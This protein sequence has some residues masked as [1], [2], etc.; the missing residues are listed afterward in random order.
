[1]H[2]RNFGCVRD[3]TVALTPLTVL[4]G[5]NDSGKSMLLR[6]VE[7]VAAASRSNKGWASALGPDWDV[8]EHTFRGSGGT[9]GVDL[10]GELQ[11][12]GSYEYAVQVQGDGHEAQLL[13]ERIQVGTISIKRGPAGFE[14]TQSAE[15]DPF[16]LS[17]K[18][19]IPIVSRKGLASL[20]SNQ[21]KPVMESLHPLL[22][23]LSGMRLFV[24]RPEELRK[25]ALFE[26]GLRPRL[27]R[28]GFG[29]PHA[30]A[31]LLLRRRDLCERIETALR[32][33]MP[34][35]KRVDAE[36]V[37]LGRS[38]ETM[39]ERGFRIELVTRQGTRVPSRL[40]SDGVLLFLA[41]LYMALGP[42]PASVLMVE[43]PETGI[44]PGLL[45]K[46]VQLFRDLTTG[47]HGGSPTQVI[48]T[49]HSPML[50]NLVEPEEIHVVAR[51]DDG[52]TTVTPF[53]TAPDL[54]R[55][56]DYQGPGE[57][58]VNEGEEYITR[59]AVVP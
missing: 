56:L 30:Y 2:V 4:V 11:A 42:D 47:A 20:S 18:D 58:W 50:L 31:E 10:A 7:A 53:T 49:T 36:P 1:L 13:S 24:L 29:L 12:G 38:N 8:R 15:P 3:A 45:R 26:D 57:I 54:G 51:G 23:L 14:L 22:S 9:I 40:V 41:Y 52:A 33:A 32:E 48:L 16:P 6:A 35:V 17:L 19:S 44:H 59:R 25:P 28:T 21:L 55:L 34:H 5:P 46:L 37:H 43:E 27:F 39:H